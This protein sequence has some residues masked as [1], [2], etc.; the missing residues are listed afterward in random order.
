[1]VCKPV[2]R[3]TQMNA[4]FVV[5]EAQGWAKSLINAERQGAGDTEFAMR[6]VEQ[7]WGISHGTLWSLTYRPPK[8]VPGSILL[9][10]FAAHEAM[11]EQQRKRYEHEAAISKAAG[12]S[13]SVLA[14]LAASLAG[15]PAE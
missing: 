10:L 2:L 5:E 11:C 9:K 6:R 12:R 8:D 4:T 3:S 13:G 1:M 15:Q 14:R 7:K